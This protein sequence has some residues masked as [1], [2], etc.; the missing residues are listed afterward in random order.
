MKTNNDSKGDEV[1]YDPLLND[2]LLQHNIAYKILEILDEQKSQSLEGWISVPNIIGKLK[3]FECS[4]KFKNLSSSVHYFCKRLNQKFKAIDKY[5]DR[6][7][8]YRINETGER[9]LRKVREKRKKV[10]K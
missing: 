1:L 2:F 8:Y 5:G 9:H 4:T 10:K 7:V 6:P 3:G